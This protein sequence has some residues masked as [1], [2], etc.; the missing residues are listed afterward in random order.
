M[1]VHQVLM[2]VGELLLRQ[3]VQDQLGILGVLLLLLIG[4]GIQARRGGLAVGAA[5]VFAV[6]MTQ[7]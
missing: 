5:V 7:A 2:G 3:Q 4:I 6:L 1:L